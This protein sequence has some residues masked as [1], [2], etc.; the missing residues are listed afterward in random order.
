MAS[1]YANTGSALVSM[2]LK[3]PVSYGCPCE[4]HS[5]AMLGG[6]VAACMTGCDTADPFT[7]TEASLTAV[8][9]CHGRVLRQPQLSHIHYTLVTHL[10]QPTAR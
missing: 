10:T 6:K 1:E 5:V 2:D 8:R 3:T 7:G 9:P 4:L